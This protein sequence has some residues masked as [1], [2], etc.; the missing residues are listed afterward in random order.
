MGTPGSPWKRS[1]GRTAIILVALFSMIA[2]ACGTSDDEPTATEPATTDAIAAPTA[3]DT[4]D[5]PAPETTEEPAPS[6][7]DE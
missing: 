1:L 4:T 7:P 2:A 5:E 3:D 6:E